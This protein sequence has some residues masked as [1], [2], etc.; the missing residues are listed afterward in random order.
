MKCT[1]G[2]FGRGGGVHAHRLC[3]IIFGP[4][5][6]FVDACDLAFLGLENSAGNTEQKAFYPLLPN[7]FFPEQPKRLC[8]VLWASEGCWLVHHLERQMTETAE[9]GAALVSQL[10]SGDKISASRAQLE[11]YGQCLKKEKHHLKHFNCHPTWSGYWMF[12]TKN[13]ATQ[14]KVNNT[15]FWY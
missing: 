8:W 15:H 13:L 12:W 7:V 4:S 11:Y 1:A 6:F 3:K 10:L 5:L 9:F 2:H 14:L